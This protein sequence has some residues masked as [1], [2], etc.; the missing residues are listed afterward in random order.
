M[1]RISM[2]MTKMCQKLFSSSTCTLFYGR[3]IIRLLR[4][5]AK[6]PKSSNSW[7]SE[8][9]EFVDMDTLAR[10]LT[11]RASSFHNLTNK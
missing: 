5:Y 7:L 3:K 6:T 8:F 2:R 4:Y 1:V 11:H 9:I 10:K